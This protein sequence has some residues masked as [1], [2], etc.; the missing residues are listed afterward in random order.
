VTDGVTLGYG[1]EVLR[2]GGAGLFQVAAQT[3]AATEALQSAPLDP[4]M[5]GLTP[6]APGF[7]AAVAAARAA[8]A[9]GFAAE[10]DRATDVAGRAATAADLGDGLTVDT[11]RIAGR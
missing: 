5:F 4:V 3:A 8:Q 1:T 2:D 11:T 9:R 10:G 7:A 6:G